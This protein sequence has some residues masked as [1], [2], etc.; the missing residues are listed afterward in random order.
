MNKQSRIVWVLLL[1]TWSWSSYGASFSQTE[2]SD[3]MS[4][5]ITFIQGDITVGMNQLNIKV[6][7]SSG[8]AITDAS[9][10]IKFGM[11]PK[12]GMMPM[13][14]KATANMV[15]DTYQADLNF[16]MAGPW[17]IEV[18]IKRPD[19]QKLKSKFSID[20]SM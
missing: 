10:K 14:M 6:M 20:V 12:D 7:D 2:E 3:N 17:S 15:G 4:A 11:I 19:K 18:K 1:L 8:A 9:I 13:S 5:H 16:A